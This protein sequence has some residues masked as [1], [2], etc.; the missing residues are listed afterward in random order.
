MTQS[1]PAPVLGF[2]NAVL[3]GI[4]A[5]IAIFSLVNAILL[6]PLPYSEPNELVSLNHYYSG[7]NLES[8]VS[9]RGLLGALLLAETIRSLLYETSPFD[10]VTLISVTTLVLLIAGISTL[11]PAIR[12][13]RLDPQVCLRSE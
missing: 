12:A 6:R 11:L 5:N 3:P 10:P 2:L 4:G 1:L 13:S 7:T 9:V 8:I